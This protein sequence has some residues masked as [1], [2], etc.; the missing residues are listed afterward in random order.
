MAALDPRS[1]RPLPLL[2]LALGVLTQGRDGA[3]VDAH[4]PD[5]AG[6]RR[7]LHAPPPTMRAAAL[8]RYRP[9]PLRVV[10]AVSTCEVGKR[11]DIVDVMA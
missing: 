3:G 7:A 9:V 4:G 6:L 1:T 2:G 5:P 8:L 10:D 11:H